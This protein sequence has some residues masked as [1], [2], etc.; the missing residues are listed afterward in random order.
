MTNPRD[1]ALIERRVLHLAVTLGLIVFVGSAT[2]LGATLLPL[3]VHDRTLRVEII[4]AIFGLAIAAF[5]AIGLYVSKWSAPD[6][7]I[8]PAT[9]A[10]EMS[11]AVTQRGPS[12]QLPAP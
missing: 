4:L 10:R 3:V 6:Q 2:A 7:L 12:E 8:K 5:G 9:P 1:Q 11:A